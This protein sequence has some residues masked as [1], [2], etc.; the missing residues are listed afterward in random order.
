MNRSVFFSVLSLGKF[1]ILEKLFKLFF[2]L[3][4]RSSF[5]LSACVN[6]SLQ[7]VFPHSIWLFKFPVRTHRIYHRIGNNNRKKKP[8]FFFFFFLIPGTR[9]ERETIISIALPEQ[10]NQTRA[11][12]FSPDGISFAPSWFILF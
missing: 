4:T 8:K 12:L 7:S 3:A 1:F 11:N 2:Y 6:V 5:T 10:A 9:N